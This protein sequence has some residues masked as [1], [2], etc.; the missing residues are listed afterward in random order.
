MKSVLCELCLQSLRTCVVLLLTLNVI[1]CFNL[2][3]RL[4]IVKYGRN[5]SYFGYSVAAHQSVEEVKLV[6]NS[7][8]LVGAPLDQNMQPNTT[9]SGALWKCPL[10]SYSDDC[11]EVITDGKRRIPKSNMYELNI[12]RNELLPPQKDEIKDNQWLGVSVR[13]HREHG[14]KVIVCAHRYIKKNV[15]Y[16]GRGLC[17]ILNSDLEVEMHYEPCSGLETTKPDEF[18]FGYCQ[19]GTSSAMLSWGKDNMVIMGSPGQ[20]NWAGNLF[21]VSVSDEV[22]HRDKTLYHASYDPPRTEKYSMLGM[23]VTGGEFFG[24]EQ[25]AYAAGAPRSNGTGEVLLFSK[26][27]KTSNQ[28]DH[29]ILEPRLVLTGEQIGS[30]FGYELTTVDV[31]GDKKPDLV[32]GAPFYFDKEGG[33]AVYIYVNSGQYCLNCQPPVRLTGKTLE[34]RFGIAIANLGDLNKDGYE[35]IAV[36]APYQ[37][38]GV[39]YI[40]LGSKNGITTEP[41][42]IIES[43]SIPTPSGEFLRTWGSSLSSGVD[44]DNNGYPDLLVGAYESGGAVLLRARPI[45]Q[46][47]TSLDPEFN[48]RNIDPSKQ[49]CPVDPTAEQSCF[50]FQTCVNIESLNASSNSRRN[51][52]LI[53]R[54]KL[55]AET[56]VPTQKFSRIY[57]GPDKAA[58]L[59]IV[60]EKIELKSGESRHCRLQTAYVKENTKDIQSPIKMKLSYSLVQQEP[61][62]IKPGSPLQSIDEFPIL[63]QTAAARVFHATFHKD[64]GSNDECESELH[65]K[66]QLQL[67]ESTEMVG[68]YELLLGQ[69]QEVLLNVSTHNAGESA[70]EAQLFIAH[71]PHLSYIGLEGQRGAL[72]NPYNTSLVV[73]ALGNPFKKNA[74]SHLK[75]R[76]DPQTLGEEPELYFTLWANSTSKDIGHEKP[77]VLKA[78]IVRKAELSLIGTHRPEHVFY[79]GLPPTKPPLYLDEVGTRLTHTYQVFNAGPWRLSSLHISV[80]WPYQV[81]RQDGKEG[82]PLL[83]LEDVPQVDGLGGGKCIVHS[84][85]NPLNLYQRPDS[86]ELELTGNSSPSSSHSR[87]KREKTPYTVRPETY[88]DP[89]GRKHKIVNMDCLLGT[90]RCFKITCDVYNL[91]ANHEATI[92]IRARLFNSTLVEDYPHVDRVIIASRAKIDIPLSLFLHQKNLTDDET[93]VKTVAMKD[94][95]QQSRPVWHIILLA[96]LL[97]LLLLIL[98]ILCLR[99]L[100]FFR[101][102]RHPPPDPTLSGNLRTT[103]EDEDDD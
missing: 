20:H 87:V 23:A 71:H 74:S 78:I 14:G 48:L 32:V 37:G 18:S 47:A 6:K 13:S 79:G 102:H 33:G 72:C 53:L 88:T 55:E 27:F 82:K 83:Y 84:E 26:S 12:D 90:A 86:L 38:N 4:P 62:R 93:Q 1:L 95:V 75:L 21:V 11:I 10:S 49:G 25:M 73:C 2:E 22:L 94:L 81:A 42:Q 69:H 56:F 80:D 5:G 61:S 16:Y 8:L 30:S 97:G 92:T 52:K 76:F 9:K 101:R 46:L 54:Y 103:Y 34:S 59:N 65:V 60:E 99:R 50:T 29:G 98:L 3:T 70:Y 64:C 39:V 41:S 40:Y 66:A 91:Y 100:G 57:F 36:G 68:S 85:V 7:W 31:N 19:T 45:I 77:L 51:G 44:M 28:P 89:D 17:Y 43:E 63:D 96:I 24:G 67:E 15:I 58:K 35:D